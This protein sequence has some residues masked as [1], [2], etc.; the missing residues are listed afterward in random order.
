MK[1]EFG[2]QGWLVLNRKQA[3]GKWRGKKKNLKKTKVDIS[4]G[5]PR[6]A[7]KVCSPSV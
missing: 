2:I 3:E 7:L 6:T 5:A 1:E 4:K